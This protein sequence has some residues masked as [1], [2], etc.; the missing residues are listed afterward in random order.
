MFWNRQCF[1]LIGALIGKLIEV[2][3]ATEARETLEFARLRIKIPVGGSANVVKS[4]DI[5]DYRC[6]ITFEE[7]MY[8]PYSQFGCSKCMEW[9]Q[10]SEGISE[11]R[12]LVTDDE[13]VNEFVFS[14][15]GREGDGVKGNIDLLED[16]ELVEYYSK[17]VVYLKKG[18]VPV[19]GSQNSEGE[20]LGSQNRAWERMEVGGALNGIENHVLG[21]LNEGSSGKEGV[22]MEEGQTQLH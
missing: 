5:N 17:V 7:D 4:I 14:D 18:E 22:V 16:P 12:Y 8:H 10:L 15:L 11:A 13:G 6:Q 21:G 9:G 1:E 19:L 20:R 3:E 2:D